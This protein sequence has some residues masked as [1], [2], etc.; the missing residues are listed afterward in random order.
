MID[1]TTKAL[2][3]SVTIGGRAFFIKTDHHTWLKFEKLVK[4]RTSFDVAFV[5]LN[6]IPPQELSYE[7]YMS[8]LEFARPQN[9]LPRPIRTTQAIAIDYELDSDLIYSA[10]LEQ[11]NIDLVDQEIHWHKFQA[12]LHGLNENTVLKKVMGYRCYEKTERK[13]DPYEEMKKA[14]WI[15]TPISQEEK[16]ELEAFSQLF[17]E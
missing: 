17:E 9:P 15:D 13:T 1:L 14:W 11:Y 8:L 6:E 12:L 16:E 3:I 4:A 2:P 10:F 7:T 5:F